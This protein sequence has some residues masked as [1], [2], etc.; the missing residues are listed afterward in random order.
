MSPKDKPV[1]SFTK[2]PVD[3]MQGRR[4]LSPEQAAHQKMMDQ[5]KT[6]GRPIGGVPPV[7]IPPLDAEPLASGGLYVLASSG[8]IRSN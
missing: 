2:P 3:V 8:S 4:V 1:T 5:I 6:G 7:R